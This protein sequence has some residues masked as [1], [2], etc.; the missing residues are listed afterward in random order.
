MAEQLSGSRKERQ[1]RGEGSQAL[2][3][4]LPTSAFQFPSD[5]VNS[6]FPFPRSS[7]QGSPALPFSLSLKE[8]RGFLQ[9]LQAKGK[10][11]DITHSFTLFSI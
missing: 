7:E 3:L 6:V 5:S 8:E 4:T 1:E 10:A 9:V 2:W 11:M